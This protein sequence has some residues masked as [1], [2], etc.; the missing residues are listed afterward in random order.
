MVTCGVPAPASFCGVSVGSS[1]MWCST[2]A[3]Q[4]TVTGFVGG[5]VTFE[6]RCESSGDLASQDTP[7]ALQ[8]ELGKAFALMP[9]R[10][11]G[12]LPCVERLR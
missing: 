9:C 5:N 12:E 6:R 8:L 7:M 4:V 10:P 11:D 3:N 2:L 1:R